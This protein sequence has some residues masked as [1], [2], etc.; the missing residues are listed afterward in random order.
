MTQSTYRETVSQSEKVLRDILLRQ[1]GMLTEQQ[2]DAFAAEIAVS[3][4]DALQRLVS[5]ACTLATPPI[6]NFYVGAVAEAQCGQGEINYFFGANVEFESQALSLVVHAEQSAIHNAW[7]GGAEKIRRLAISDAPC[8]YCR[9]FI[10]ELKDAAQIDILL[11]GRH[12]SFDTLLPSAFG[13]LDLNNSTQ[14]LGSEPVKLITSDDVDETLKQHAEN[15][16]VPYTGNCSAVMLITRDGERF[17][18]RYAENAA[19]SPSL[20]PLQGA[21]SQLHLAGYGFDEDTVS[22]VHLLELEGKGNQRKVAEAVLASYDFSPAFYHH[23]A[24][25]A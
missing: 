4:L 18:G 24:K 1:R 17:Y 14:L 2:V 9:Q 13:P 19:Y 10:N 11:P 21:I 15:A 25:P 6:S 16:Y 8:G 20:S 22:E 23:L 3:P 7:L 5:L 12:V